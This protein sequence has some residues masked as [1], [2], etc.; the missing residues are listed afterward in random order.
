MAKKKYSGKQKQGQKISSDDIQKNILDNLQINRFLTFIIGSLLFF[1][2]IFLSFGI[3][4]NADHWAIIYAIDNDASNAIAVTQRTKWYNDNKFFGYGNLYFRLAH[5]IASLNPFYNRTVVEIRKEEAIHFSLMLVSM[6]SLLGVSFLISWVI[7]SS[8]LELLVSVTLV[9]FAFVFHSGW[10]KMVFV[11]H[12][13]LLLTFFTTLSVLLTYKLLLST[14][15]KRLFY[16]TAIS[17]GLVLAIKL[18]GIFYLPGLLLIFGFRPFKQKA[19]KILKFFSIIFMGYF[20]VGFPQNFNLVKTYNFLKYQ[21]S[22]SKMLTWESFYKWWELL[23]TQS[24]MLMLFIIILGLVWRKSIERKIDKIIITKILLITLL[25]FVIL[26]SRK[27]I[28]GSDHYILP[29][30]GGM[31]IGIAIIVSHFMARIK[32]EFGQNLKLIFLLLTAFIFTYFLPNYS[33][34][35]L[36]AQLKDRKEARKV[37]G[38]ISGLQKKGHRVLL[39]PY[40]PFNRRIKNAASSWQTSIKIV[41]SGQF[42]VLGLKPLYYQRYLKGKEVSDYVKNYAS[43][44]RPIRE[45]YQLFHEKNEVVDPHGKVWQKIYDGNWKI[46]KMVKD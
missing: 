19:I 38:I 1:Q 24:W 3:S 20:V 28:S 33:P 44:W 43:S 23:F 17:W 8:L 42:E 12:P 30:I 27:I 9:N 26:L 31:A 18:S 6:I 5:S 15:S 37:Y 2:I 29:I 34:K 35:I 32:I 21:S 4:K 36:S 11:A 7:S 22:Y 41:H 46:W 40:V 16:G 25:P 10:G 39:D 45:F 14:S 13:D